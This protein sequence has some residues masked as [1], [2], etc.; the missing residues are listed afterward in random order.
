MTTIQ[1]DRSFRVELT[2]A[3]IVEN[4][5]LVDYVEDWSR[6][7]SPSRARRRLKR[8]FRQ[9][10]V[11]CAV[12]QKTDRPQK[13]AAPAR[14]RRGAHLGAQPEAR[15]HRRQAGAEHADALRRPR[16]RAFVGIASLAE[17]CEMSP[18][19]VRR[20]LVWLEEIGA[21][22]RVPQ[23]LDEN[24]NRNSTARGK[25]TTDL[26]R[27]LTDADPE[28][29]EARAAGE[30]VSETAMTKPTRLALAASKG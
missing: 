15:Q 19:T 11:T 7:R 1:W 4:A 14:L 13:A 12:P 16:G 27:L 5:S 17:D 26:I 29:I 2:S 8:G 6:V 30:S 22:V 21:I 25:R 28:L 10:I 24:G 9:N 23:W 18:D 3:R 20:R